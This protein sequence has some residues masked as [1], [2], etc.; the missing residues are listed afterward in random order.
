MDLV[1]EFMFWM[2]TA[3]FLASL[4]SHW[5]ATDRIARWDFSP[6]LGPPNSYS[7]AWLYGNELAAFYLV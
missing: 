4:S 2:F 3:L 6:P 7:F 1:S 5:L